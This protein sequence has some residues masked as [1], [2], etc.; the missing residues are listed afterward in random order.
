MTP[1]EMILIIRQTLWTTFELAA[2]FLLLALVVGI[3]IAFLQSM[4]Q[5][6]EMTLSFVPKMLI[7]AVALAI[8]FPWM[9]KILTKFTHNLL[10]H[11]WDKVTSSIHYVQ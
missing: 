8:L 6:Q 5:L 2:P 3:L 7:L 9:I 1:E 4:T 10:I 11:Q